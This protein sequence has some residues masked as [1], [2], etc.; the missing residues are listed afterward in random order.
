[1]LDDVPGQMPNPCF[2]PAPKS[3]STDGY[4]YTVD[5]APTGA[6][7]RREFLHGRIAYELKDI[8]RIGQVDTDVSPE[9]VADARKEHRELLKRDL[10]HFADLPARS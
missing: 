5:L 6:T 1:V 7:Y 9:R 8:R 2:F 10:V 4:G 3:A